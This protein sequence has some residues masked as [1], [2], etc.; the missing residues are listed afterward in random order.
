MLEVPPMLRL[1]VR[2]L[3]AD[4]DAAPSEVAP[5]IDVVAGDVPGD[6]QRQ[7]EVEVLAQQPV[8]PQGRGQRQ[9]EGRRAEGP[10]DVVEEHHLP[11]FQGD[12]FEEED[13]DRP[14]RGLA[15]TQELVVEGYVLALPRLVS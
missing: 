5:Q 12:R 11:S 6:E 3:E 7:L 13:R 10:G 14:R 9:V 4:V 15:A 8:L 2:R 1:L